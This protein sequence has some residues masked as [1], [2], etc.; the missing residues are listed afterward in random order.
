[1]IDAACEREPGQP[2]QRGTGQPDLVDPRDVGGAVDGDQLQQRRQPRRD[3]PAR[4]RAEHPGFGEEVL[5]ETAARRAERAANRQL[6]A[7]VQ[8]AGDEQIDRIR[9]RDE[10]HEPDRGQ[11]EDQ[12][13]ADVADDARP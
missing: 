9:A 11:H 8:R 1:M 13:G 2:R 12:R 10:Q 7:A 3:R 6:A 4:R 5:Q